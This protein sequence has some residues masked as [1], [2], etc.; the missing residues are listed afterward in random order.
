MGLR[1]SRT[2]VTPSNSSVETLRA[3][4]EIDEERAGR[5]RT[6]DFVVRDHA[7]RHVDEGGQLVLREPA[8]LAQLRQAC[9]EAG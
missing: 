2:G 9:T 4:P 1:V 3:R 7:P 5:L 8:R 6:L